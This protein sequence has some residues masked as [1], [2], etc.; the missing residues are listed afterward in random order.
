M[1]FAPHSRHTENKQEDI[2]KISELEILTDSKEA[3]VHIIRSKDDKHFFITGHLEYD[4]DTLSLEYFRDKNKGLDIDLPKN[5]FPDN[6]DT[7]TPKNIWRSHAHLLF[8][9]WLNYFVYQSIS[10]GVNEM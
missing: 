5:Y 2:E 6:D 4:Y 3:G 1:F 8:S 10:C 7:K 9:N